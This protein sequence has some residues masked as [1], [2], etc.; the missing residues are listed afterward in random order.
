M[1]VVSNSSP[2]IGLARIRKLDL[3]NLNYG[4]L[5]VPKAVWEEVV[6]Q[7]DNKLG[8]KEIRKA[9][10]IETVAVENKNLA[11]SLRQDLGAGE[12]ESIALAIELKADLL[13][14]D[15]LLGRETAHYFGLKYIGVI[16]II[17]EAKRKGF[18]KAIKPLLDK[19]RDQAAFR[20]SDSLYKRVLSDEGED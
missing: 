16:G 1:I 15:E 7:G 3:I 13:L 19:L 5:I 18:I 8:A 10:W 12:A 9:V 4:K 17:L 11:L 6:I 14:M 20:M 2:L